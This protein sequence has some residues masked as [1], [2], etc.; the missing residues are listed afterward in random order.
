[1]IEGVKNI[2]FDYSGTLRDDL[3][4]TFAITM[5]VFEKL[6][7]KPISLEE[8]RNQMCLPYMNFYV[9]YFPNV[10]QKRIDSPFLRAWMKSA[11]RP[12]DSIAVFA[13]LWN[14]WRDGP[15]T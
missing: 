14:C 10:G 4:W 1:M 3:D 6:G 8:Y 9:K 12:R 7:R 13:R 2:I 11:S 15:S 5:R